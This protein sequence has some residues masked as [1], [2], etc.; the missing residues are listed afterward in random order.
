MDWRVVLALIAVMVV[1]GVVVA[2]AVSR[3]RWRR[4]TAAAEARCRLLEVEVIRWRSMV[5]A[6]GMSARER[7]DAIGAAI[8]AWRPGDDR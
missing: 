2:L 5:M 8:A 6:G 4:A 7:A 3:A 1:A